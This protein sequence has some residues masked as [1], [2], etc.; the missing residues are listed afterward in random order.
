MDPNSVIIIDDCLLNKEEREDILEN[1]I[2]KEDEYILISEKIDTN[3]I[4]ESL[5]K[6][7]K[8][9]TNNSEALKLSISGNCFINNIFIEKYSSNDFK[10]LLHVD[11]KNKT[12]NFLIGILM[13]DN[14]NQDS[15]VTISTRDYSLKNGD[16]LWFPASWCYPFSEKYAK[17]AY[18]LKII[19]NKF[20]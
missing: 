17:D 4:F 2:E 5:V 14:K 19:I 3:K 15:I 20:L 10:Q 8:I 18:S 16:L 7:S 12:Y 6:Y 1:T 11:Y 13:L 9:T